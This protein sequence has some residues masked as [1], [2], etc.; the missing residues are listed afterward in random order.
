MKGLFIHE[1]LKAVAGV[2]SG[3]RNYLVREIEA[4]DTDSRKLVKNG[5][6]FAIK[7]N[8]VDS[9]IFIKDL[10]KENKIICAIGEAS[11]KE[12]FGTVD[13]KVEGIYI[14]VQN[15]YRALLEVAK[16]YR[17]LLK[18]KIV[19]ITGSVG[20]TGTK[21][22]IATVLSQKYK[23][24]KTQGNYNNEI[25]VPLT[26]FGIEPEHEIAVV[27]MGINGFG[28]MST[29][30]SV[31]RPDIMVMTNI[32]HCHLEQLIDRDGV[33]K[34]KSEVLD[35]LMPNGKIVLN[36][37]DD[38]LSE[39]HE[40]SIVGKENKLERL[41]PISF[42]IRNQK[43]NVLAKEIS[44]SDDGCADFSVERDG[45]IFNI[46][47]NLI[48]VHHIYNALAAIVVAELFD[49]KHS[50][51]IAG[52][53][54]TDALSGRANLYHLSNG[55]R[56]IDDCYNANPDSMRAALSSLSGMKGENKIAIIGDMLELGENSEVEHRGIAEFISRKTEIKRV[57]FV[58]KQMLNAYL[59]IKENEDIESKYFEDIES[60]NQKINSEIKSEDIILIKASHSMNFDKIKEN[61]MLAFSKR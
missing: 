46:S 27:E 47:L 12:V 50:D 15:V 44:L 31:V 5:L 43:A 53:E 40:W 55:I 22:M 19:G 11:Y 41:I 33:L 14:Q 45:E 36:S 37:D 23:V 35:Y 3:N 52:L 30:A 51:M 20:K 54:Q 56:L 38:K 49:M 61:L 42:G 6:F 13:E 48:G 57:C 17:S 26:I 34:A 25:G 16:L 1:V 7:G 60:L 10:F 24:H 58:G 21:E 2:C 4:A 9:H 18:V 29:L 8:K 28:Q 32:G 59:V 39:I